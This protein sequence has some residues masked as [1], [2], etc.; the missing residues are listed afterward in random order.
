MAVGHVIY[1]QVI[2]NEV[3]SQ[4]EIG[5]LSTPKQISAINWFEPFAFMTSRTFICHATY[6][7]Y[8]TSFSY[9]SK[10]MPK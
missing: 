5:R 2:V 3:C 7:T 4:F 6:T 10:L 1:S 8:K 9:Q